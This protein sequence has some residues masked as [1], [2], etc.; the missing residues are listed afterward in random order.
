MAMKTNATAI[1]HSILAIGVCASLAAGALGFGGNA[2]ARVPEGDRVSATAAE[3][4][5][6]QD[7]Y[8]DQKSIANDVMLGIY[9]RGLARRNAE[10]AAQEYKNRGCDGMYGSIDVAP[11][12]S[13]QQVRPV[14]GVMQAAPLTGGVIMN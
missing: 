10:W 2:E 5:L 3:C 4:G 1:K 8:D 13:R 12:P 6:L 7:Y 9:E 14:S 11:A